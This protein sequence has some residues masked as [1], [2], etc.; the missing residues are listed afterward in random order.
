MNRG[1]SAAKR[2]IVEA[3]QIVVNEGRAMQQFDRRGGCL[4]QRR[5][6]VAAGVCNC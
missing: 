6:I 1:F 3:G 4:G 2:G 5:L